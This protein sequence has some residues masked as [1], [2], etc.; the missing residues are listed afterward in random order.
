MVTER[1]PKQENEKPGK[2]VTQKAM[3][4][5]KFQIPAAKIGSVTLQQARLLAK[6]EVVAPRGV[7]KP[8][9]VASASV[10]TLTVE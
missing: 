10:G 8:N 9:V 4:P 3:K 1:K 2:K 6:T 5:G 7:V